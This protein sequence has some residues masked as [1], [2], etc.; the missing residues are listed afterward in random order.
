MGQL[1]KAAGTFKRWVKNWL[2][3]KIHLELVLMSFCCMSDVKNFH[4]YA[5]WHYIKTA[6]L[7]A[8]W[9]PGNVTEG[10][11]RWQ[12]TVIC[13]YAALITTKKAT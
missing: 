6:S 4:A 7:S 11:D 1:Y 13:G 12:V 5:L 2:N 8:T 9:S 3:K 10:R